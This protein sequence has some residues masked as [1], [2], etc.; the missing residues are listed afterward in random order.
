LHGLIAS[1]GNREDQT[2]QESR[3]NKLIAESAKG[4]NKSLW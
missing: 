4:A 1:V 2:Y 3:A